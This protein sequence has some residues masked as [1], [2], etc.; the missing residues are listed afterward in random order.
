MYSPKLFLCDHW[1]FGP[2]IVAIV[3]QA[4]IWR[5]LILYIHPTTERIFLHYNIIFGIDLV[6][7]W[8]HAYFIPGV[9]WLILMVNLII[10]W[11]VYGR[12]KLLARVLI[13]FLVILQ[14][15]LLLAAY[16]LVGLNG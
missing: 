15:G 13:L 4:A 8:W 5:Q 6:G 11:L 9:G 12:D 1:V 16:S 7:E 2:L 10:A 14:V 3:V